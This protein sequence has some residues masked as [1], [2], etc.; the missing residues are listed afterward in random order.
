M[1]PPQGVPEDRGD[2]ILSALRA[3]IAS[4]EIA[5]ATDLRAAAP[6]VK[7]TA[8]SLK[9][10]EPL[11]FCRG[12]RT[13]PTLDVQVSEGARER[14]LL[15]ADTFLRAAAALGWTVRASSRVETAPEN[16]GLKSPRSGHLLVEGESIP[17]RIEERLKSEP[18]EPTPQ[19]ARARAA[20]IPLS[21]AAE[22]L[23]A[24]RSAA[25]HPS[26]NRLLESPKDVV[27]PP[28]D[29]ASRISSGKSCSASWSMPLRS[30]PTAPS[31]S[32]KNAQ[33]RKKSAGAKCSKPNGK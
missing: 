13:G 24:H 5:P 11:E 23:E 9:Y 3:R 6:S 28:R 27:R 10:P 15:L 12:E 14:A 19:E 20:R 2:E 29:G 26:G 8:R 1:P 22:N 33:S 25:A 17:F 7:R 16:G 18:R 32:A 31:E 21:R 30:R 4:L